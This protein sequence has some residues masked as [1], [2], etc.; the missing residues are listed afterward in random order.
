MPGPYGVS[1]Y[2]ASIKGAMVDAGVRDAVFWGTHLGAASGLLLACRTPNLFVSLVLEG[3]VFP[4][5]AMPAVAQVLSRVSDTARQKGMEAARKTWWEEGGWFAV[6]RDRPQECRAA[7][8]REIIDAFE[9]APWMDSGLIGPITPPD[10]DLR[11]L[12]IPV[13]IMNGEH[14]LPDFLQAADELSAL[15]PH[16]RRAIIA[17]GGGFPF[18]EFPDAVNAE[19]QAFLASL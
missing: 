4:G 11:N 14:D 8:Q 2:A 19:V 9:G 15:L 7:E 1:E 13:L 3:P 5:R 6:M 10:D 17:G 12:G 16:C 18:W